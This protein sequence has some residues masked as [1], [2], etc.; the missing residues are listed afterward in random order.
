MSTS[1]SPTSRNCVSVAGVP[2]MNARERPF[3]SIT[4]RSI[5]RV[6]FFRDERAFFEPACHRFM[7]REFGGDVGARF[8]RAHDAR[9]AARAEREGEGVDE[10]RLAGAGLA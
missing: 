1:I 7:R 3:E 4:R 9:V 5:D 8:A 2:L 10:D 6:R